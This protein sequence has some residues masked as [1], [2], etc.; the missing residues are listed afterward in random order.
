MEE[1]KSDNEIREYMVERYGDFISYKPPVVVRIC[2]G[3]VL[4]PC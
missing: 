4:L 3:L 1:G 2:C